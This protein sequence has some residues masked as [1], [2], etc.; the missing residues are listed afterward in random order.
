[1]WCD[2]HYYFSYKH[3]FFLNKNGN[4]NF[5]HINFKE[6][7]F[8]IF[9]KYIYIYIY[10][11][12]NFSVLST[13]HIWLKIEFLKKR[14]KKNKDWK[15]RIFYYPSYI[16]YL[17]NLSIKWILSSYVVHLFAPHYLDTY[18]LTLALK[19]TRFTHIEH[20]LP[21]FCTWCIKIKNSLYSMA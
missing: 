9:S 1:M 14:K 13:K 21:I 11:I 16:F 10:S 5:L 18:T 20:H 2:H 7:I 12:L 6:T 3:Y 8:S 19:V 4:N 17:P 15:L